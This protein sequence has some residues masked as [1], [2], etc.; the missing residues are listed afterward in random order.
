MTFLDLQKTLAML[1]MPAGLFWVVILAA[2]ILL[3]RRRQWGPAFL[4]ILVWIGY[5]MAGNYY[6]GG[7]LLARLE[8][9]IPAVDLRTVEPFDAVCVLGGG[10][11]LD[12]TGEPIL[13]SYGDRVATAARLWH[14]GKARYL[15]ASGASQDGSGE[16]R[17]GG[18][19]TRTLW[20]S[21]GVPDEAII[22]IAEPCFITRDEILAYRRLQ[23]ARHW[24]RLALVSSAWHLPRAM[25]LAEKSGLSFTP[26]GADWRGRKRKVQIQRLVPQAAGFETTN[27]ACWEFLGRMVGR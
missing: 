23:D 10:T 13:S 16:T 9:R 6:V 21:L 2:G 27:Y 4:L 14:L 26:I 7:A 1:L 20:R 17:D 22:V 15:V 11:D 18:E 8:R 5:G 25:A 3:L 24:R 19:E 12:P